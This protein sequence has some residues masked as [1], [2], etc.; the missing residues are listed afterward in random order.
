M[1]KRGQ[2]W[3]FRQNLGVMPRQEVFTCRDTRTIRA[4][5]MTRK[6]GGC[7][8]G[9]SFLGDFSRVA[10]GNFCCY[11]KLL[12]GLG[13]TSCA[14]AGIFL[15]RSK[16][17]STLGISS[18]VATG[19]SCCNDKRFL[20]VSRQGIYVPLQE[21]LFLHFCFFSRFSRFK[22]RIRVQKI[23]ITKC[24]TYK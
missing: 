22:E 1:R 2:K 4:C 24:S 23:E 13:F 8:K 21:C 10:A 16:H 18:R 15:C 3:A 11:G 7:G 12:S 9:L 17:V 5:V 6:S 20:R 19:F 14:A